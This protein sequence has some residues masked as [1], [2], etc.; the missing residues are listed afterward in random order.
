MEDM[1]DFIQKALLVLFIYTLLLS[2][3]IFH[4]ATIK[5]INTKN[6]HKYL[7]KS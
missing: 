4:M 1:I 3:K 7:P 2:F 5:G 6:I